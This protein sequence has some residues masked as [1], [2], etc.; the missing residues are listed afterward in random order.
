MDTFSYWLWQ[1]RVA[2][3]SI[4]CSWSGDWWRSASAYYCAVLLAVMLLYLPARARPFWRRLLPVS[5][6]VWLG[7]SA[8]IALAETGRL[9]AAAW[10]RSIL[11]EAALLGQLFSLGILLAIPLAYLVFLLRGTRAPKAKQ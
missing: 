4:F 11:R 8:V 6:L 5:L 2:F 7:G 3:A 10:L 1:Q 9:A